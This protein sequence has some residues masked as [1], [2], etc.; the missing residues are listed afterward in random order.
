MIDR[1]IR[2]SG[3]Q[4]NLAQPS[5]Q[6]GA[7]RREPDSPVDEIAG[8][9]DAILL[10][11]DIGQISRRQWILRLPFHEIGKNRGGQIQ[12]IRLECPD[13]LRK[14]S[15]RGLIIFGMRLRGGLGDFDKAIKLL[16]GIPLDSVEIRIP[17]VFVDRGDGNVRGRN[18]RF[19]ENERS[20][21]CVRIGKIEL[22][23]IIRHDPHDRTAAKN[24]FSTDGGR[25]ITIQDF[26]SS[27]YIRDASRRTEDILAQADTVLND[28]FRQDPPIGDILIGIVA[29]AASFP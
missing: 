24:G 23:Q 2:A 5:P 21:W 6:V 3:A 17:G 1:Q 10:R 7:I 11:G 8:F 28:M 4:E 18:V 29:K 9:Q 13:P 14:C 15:R 25:F 19:R 22:A 20:E 26:R 12:M 16:H 27:Q